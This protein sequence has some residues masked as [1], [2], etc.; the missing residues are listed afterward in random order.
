MLCN[1]F[2]NCEKEQLL[3]CFGFCCIL[4]AV[5]RV[6]LLMLRSKVKGLCTPGDNI[7]VSGRVHALASL[8]TW[9]E[10]TL[11]LVE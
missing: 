6:T 2:S 3:K 7:A 10:V 11:I 4:H 8:T 1:E 9:K 5:V